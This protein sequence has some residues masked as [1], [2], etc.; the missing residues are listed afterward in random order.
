MAGRL[1][2]VGCTAA[3]LKMSEVAALLAE[4]QQLARLCEELLEER[5]ELE[6]RRRRL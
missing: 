5:R 4:H 2:F 6:L 3:E 1:R